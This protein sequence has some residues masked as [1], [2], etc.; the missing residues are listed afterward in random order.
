MLNITL[1]LG[2]NKHLSSVKVGDS[3]PYCPQCI[4]LYV[5]MDWKLVKA[6]SKQVWIQESP[7]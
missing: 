5:Q 7:H 4:L 1:I 3:Q 2:P 6:N